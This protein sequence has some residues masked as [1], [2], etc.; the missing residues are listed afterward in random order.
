MQ[1]G[2]E[3]DPPAVVITFQSRASIWRVATP[4]PRPTE[5]SGLFQLGKQLF[6]NVRNALVQYGRVKLVKVATDFLAQPILNHGSE[7]RI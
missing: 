5:S 7:A 1:T 3:R 6:E 2:I 4:P